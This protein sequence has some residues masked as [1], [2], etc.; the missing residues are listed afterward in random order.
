MHRIAAALFGIGLFA[1]SPAQA[2]FD[3]FLCIQGPSIPGESQDT[4]FKNC[5]DVPAGS[6]AGFLEG[7]TAETRDLR[8]TKFI[9]SASGP[10]SR[11]MVN[12]TVLASSTFHFRQAGGAAI[13]TPY[14]TIRLVDSLVTSVAMG[15]SSGDDRLVESISLR[16]EQIEYTYRK[17]KSDGSLDVPAVTCWNVLTNTSTIGNCP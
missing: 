1:S 15:F 8:F 11:A 7:A 5:I 14:Y 17:T 6:M 2:A 4:A 12:G 9:D 16:P 10:L 3:V 13:P